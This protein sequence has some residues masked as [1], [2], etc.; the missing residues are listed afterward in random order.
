MVNKRGIIFLI[1][2]LGIFVGGSIAVIFFQQN[3]EEQF[4]KKIPNEVSAIGNQ[5]L[6]NFLERDYQ[7]T[8][9]LFV[10][11]ANNKE[12]FLESLIKISNYIS[13]LGKLEDSE[14]VGYQ[15]N[16]NNGVRFDSVTLQL[17]FSEEY[18]LYSFVAT[19]EGTQY[20]LYRTNFNKIEGSLKEINKFDFNNTGLI[21]YVVLVLGVVFFVFSVYTAAV[22]FSSNK[23]RRVLWSIFAL[24]GIAKFILVW[25]T[26]EWNISLLNINIP[27]FL[28]SR[29]GSVASFVFSI[30]FPLGAILYWAFK[31]NKNEEVKSEELEVIDQVITNDEI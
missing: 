27:T 28:I 21:H 30:S 26:G 19:K 5:A 20:R 29:A 17:K 23:K 2:V 9:K 8:M 25:N 31:H 12:N 13:G 6:V 7:S 4:Y 22:C 1:V 16:V 24:S 11:E 14:I 18:I 10:D 3:I 15:F